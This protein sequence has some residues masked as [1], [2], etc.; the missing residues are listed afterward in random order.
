MLQSLSIKNV[1][2]IKN[3]SIE[4]NKG[5]NILLGE[6]GA[7]KSI[8]FDSLNFVLG[9][10]ADKTL[11]RNGETE[12]RVDALFSDISEENLNLIKT[13]GIDDSEIL[14][15]RTFNTEGKSSI[16]INGLLSSQSILKEIRNVLLDSYSQHESV[17]LLKSKSHIS[18]LDKFGENK[19][20]NQKNI[21]K[22]CFEEYSKI[23]S[24]ISN[25]GGN[26]FD[27]EREKSILE[28]QIDEIQS[29]NLIVGE[30]DE[31]KE[32]L[33]LLN[34][35]EKIVEA[36][37]NCELYLSE[38]STSC[39]N[40]LQQASNELSQ[41]NN[42]ENISECKER[43]DSAKLEIYDVYE[44]LSDI[45][46]S[47]D[48]NEKEFETLDKRYDLIK[49]IIKKYGGTIESSL[50]FLEESKQKLLELDDYEYI[51]EKLKK[52]KNDK[53]IQ[54]NKECNL[55]TSMRKDIAKDIE[56][57]IV[58][59]LK[60][61]GMKSSRFEVKFEELSSPTINGKDSIE[62]VFSA[63]KGEDVKALAKTASGGELSRFMLAIKNI[64]A[65][66]G[67]AETL[68]FDEI[69]SGISGE[70]GNIVGS[71]LKNITDYAQVICITHLPQV[72]CYGDNFYYVYKK[73]SQS[74]TLTHIEKLENEQIPY[75]IAKMVVGDD[76]SDISLSQAKEMIKKIN[77]HN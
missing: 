47:I 71:K 54:L 20:L 65:K 17:E 38:T 39:L 1:A 48:F 7:G 70:T 30:D 74:E 44:T 52:E 13:Y 61:L 15:S 26:D 34:N 66:T 69:D 42:F 21:V 29:A 43:L 57:K 25:L 18:M 6:T 46:N 28:F 75:N 62:F 73:E 45:K 32:R 5:L 11:I 31:I 4:F 56:I 8:I 60:D 58:A 68:I 40:N 35:A 14:I 10:K 76:V 59:E 16:R 3:I 23:V 55:L 64:F 77:K 51:V 49:S 37:N 67:G 12:M 50:S 36:V 9:A 27:R 53:F 41:L 19:L 22:N 24:K 72:A 2:L 63:N 33:H